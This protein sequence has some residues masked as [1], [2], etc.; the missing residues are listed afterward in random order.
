MTNK[1]IKAIS[2]L[3]A[4]QLLSI[5]AKIENQS[6]CLAKTAE[7]K[8]RLLRVAC[9]AYKINNGFWMRIKCLIFHQ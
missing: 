3:N 9:Q 5:L 4:N 7:S 2:E 6:I 8:K 1:L